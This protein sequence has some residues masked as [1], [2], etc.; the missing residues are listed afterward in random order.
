MGLYTEE[1]KEAMAKEYEKSVRTIERFLKLSSL[2]EDFLC[3][4]DEYEMS[5]ERGIPKNIGLIIADMK[6]ENQEILYIY[7]FSI[8]ISINYGKSYRLYRK[9]YSRS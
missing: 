6:P 8:N 4:I 7:Q 2:T 3:F 5:K 1:S 9:I